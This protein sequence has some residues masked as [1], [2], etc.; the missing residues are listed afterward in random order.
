MKRNK[1]FCLNTEKHPVTW[2]QTPVWSLSAQRFLNSSTNVS[3]VGSLCEFTSA[4]MLCPISAFLLRF[5][6]P[7]PFGS[8]HL[9]HEPSAAEDLHAETQRSDQTTSPVS[10]ICHSQSDTEKQSVHARFFTLSAK[11][12]R[13]ICDQLSEQWSAET[14]DSRKRKA[15]MESDSTDSDRQTVSVFS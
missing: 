6:R 10:E 5:V 7:A 3:L 2:N 11:A 14:N 12:H 15:N 8:D 9:R 4:N 13:H 1:Y